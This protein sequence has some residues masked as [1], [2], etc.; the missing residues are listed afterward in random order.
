MTIIPVINSTDE[1]TLRNRI[2]LA[3]RILPHGEKI[4]IDVADGSFTAG[5][6]TCINPALYRELL[7]A[8]LLTS[9]V[10]LMGTQAETLTEAW[11]PVK[12]AEIIVHIETI[13]DPERLIRRVKA[14]GVGVYIGLTAN[15]DLKKAQAALKEAHGCLV[16][17]VDPGK[18]GQDFQPAVL[19]LVRS[20]RESFPLLP[21]CIDGGVTLDL[22]S[23]CQHAGATELAVG[24]HIFNAADPAKTYSSFVQAAG[25]ILKE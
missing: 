7:P 10:H 5:Y 19:P 21:I 22:I 8:S 12:P 2:A 16:L 20:I 1:S 23:S 9:S 4:H 17:A 25:D 3:E 11:L 15:S 14:E 18:S 13:R 6:K 24:A